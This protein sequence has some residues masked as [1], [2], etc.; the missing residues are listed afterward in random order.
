MT[1]IEAGT[2][3]PRLLGDI[4]RRTKKTEPQLQLNLQKKKKKKNENP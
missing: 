4:T 1:E 2:R 3:R